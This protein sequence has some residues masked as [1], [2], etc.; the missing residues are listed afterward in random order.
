MDYKNTVFL[1]KTDFS[2]K[3]NLSQKEPGILDNWKG[4]YKKIRESSKGQKKFILNFGPPYANGHIHIGHVLTEV[5]KDIVNKTHQMMGADAPMVPGWDCHGLP[6]EWKVEEEYRKKG[7]SK[8]D[9]RTTEEILEFRE[10]CRQFANKWIEVQKVEFERLGIIADFENPYITMDFDIEGEVVDQISHF[11]LNGTLY[12]GLRPVMWSVVEQTALADN[13]VEYKNIVSPSIYVGFPIKG[14]ENTLAVIWTTTPWT[15]PANQAISYN[16]DFIYTLIKLSDGRNILIAKDCL[17]R[18]LT[19]LDIQDYQHVKDLKGE[20]LE[21]LVSRHPLD[22]QGYGYDVPFLHGNHV[23]TDA[24]TGLV[25][26]APA[27]GLED[28]EVCLKHNIQVNEVIADDGKYKENLPLFAG[29]HIFK[30]NQSVIEAIQKAECLM[31]ESTIEHSYPHSWRSKKPLIYRATSQWFIDI[32]KTGIRKT[33]L[34]E[35]EKV[36]WFPSGGKTRIRSMVEGRPDWCVSRQRFWGTPLAIFVNKDT[37]EPLRDKKVQDRI[38]EKIKKYGGDAWYTTPNE[39][40]LGADYCADH[41]EKV[42]DV[43]DVW[44]DA[45]CVHHYVLK[46][47]PELTWPADLY[48]EGSDQ[49]RGWFQSSLLEAVGTVGSAPY[50]Q[51]VT[52]G[53]VLDEHGYKMSKSTGNVLAPQ[54]IMDQYGADIL[55]QWVIFSDYTE[56]LRIGNDILKRH[57]DLYRRFRNTLRYLLGALYGYDHT[58]E[59]SYEDLPD[60]EK[61][62]LHQLAELNELHKDCTTHFKYSK[63]YEA[64]HNFCTNDLSSFYF[65]IRKDSLYCDA[66]D[67]T[68]RKSTRAV[69]YHLFQALVRFL[70]P[71]LSFTAEEAFSHFFE[72]DGNSIHMSKLY[73][74]PK[75]WLNAVLAKYWDK[76]R[77]IRR[78]ATGALEVARHDKLIGSS[79]QAHVEIYFTNDEQVDEKVLN[80]IFITSSVCIIK[81]HSLPKEAFVLAD[82]S[83]VGVIVSK[84]EGEKCERCWKIVSNIEMKNNLCLRCMNVI[85]NH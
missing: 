13:E 31:H 42:F 49:H 25:H 18:F 3:G 27:H 52:H 57:Q 79:L 53:F 36:K 24:G 69:M 63:F 20:E 8:S 32:D 14:L 15:L 9:F 51:V 80:E 50:K 85:D 10:T 48:L 59:V 56:D 81:K 12:K 74:I 23:T 71:V 83:D 28:F 44:F 43:L 73:E 39:D 66:E 21:E 58:Q 45:G 72:Y 2:M 1:P 46:K 78:V 70:A 30:A 19:D 26:T 29:Q 7:K 82:V 76:L 41:Y 34:E 35:I 68:V 4:L 22:K 54:Q 5:L 40:F 37:G 64:L 6:I 60:L 75:S 61:Y 17:S 67:G 77:D 62:L 47:R 11:L 16:K 33:A 55:R 84:A 38:V 65:D